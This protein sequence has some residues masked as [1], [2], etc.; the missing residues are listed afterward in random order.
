MKMC[1]CRR[2]QGAFTM[3]EHIAGMEALAVLEA[4]AAALPSRST[5]TPNTSGDGVMVS[6]PATCRCKRQV[7]FFRS[8]MGEWGCAACLPDAPAAG[9]HS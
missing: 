6:P 1:H 8:R 7:V 2:C 5:M 4:R 3:A 9:G